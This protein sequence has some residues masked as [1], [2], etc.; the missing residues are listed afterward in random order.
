MRGLNNLNIEGKRVGK[1]NG[2]GQNQSDTGSVRFFLFFFGLIGLGISCMHGLEPFIGFS[3]LISF[4]LDELE[5]LIR[6]PWT[7]L[8]ELLGF[9][10]PIIFVDFLN[11]VVFVVSYIVGFRRG[12]VFL[13]SLMPFVARIVGYTSSRKWLGWIATLFVNGP[14][15]VVLFL[16]SQYNI[17]SGIFLGLTFVVVSL[18]NPFSVR[19]SVWLF[20]TGKA[21]EF[22]SSRPWYSYNE[23]E[24]DTD[25]A[26]DDHGAYGLALSYVAWG[27]LAIVVF[28]L[29]LDIVAVNSDIILFWWE[30]VLCRAEVDCADAGE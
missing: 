14:Y 4:A 6:W 30:E 25:D 5:S 8:A 13:Y 10:I 7:F 9:Q 19:L 2:D 26:S 17:F 3:K 27:V 28:F 22:F 24:K 1:V 20:G 21:D 29:L 12:E 15:L 18:S 16:I 23:S 11:G